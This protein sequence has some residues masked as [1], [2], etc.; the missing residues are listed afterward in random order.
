[1]TVYTLY[2]PKAGQG[3][4]FL[5]A[6]FA[7]S[8][9]KRGDHVILIDA[10][11][12]SPGMEKYFPEAEREILAKPGL[13]DL[14]EDF[15]HHKIEAQQSPET[16][17]TIPQLGNY[18]T[19]VWGADG[20]PD[21]GS[22]S[23]LGAGQRDHKQ[24][25]SYQTTVKET[26]STPKIRMLI[27]HGFFD[28]FRDELQKRSTSIVIDTP[29]G[30]SFISD[31]FLNYM[32]DLVIILS[33]ASFQ[34]R[35]LTV[36]TIDILEDTS[37]LKS[38]VEAPKIPIVVLPVLKNLQHLLP[39]AQRDY[40]YFF[41]DSFKLQMP[42]SWQFKGQ[43]YWDLAI[44]C[45]QSLPASETVL[46]TGTR[47]GISDKGVN[48]MAQLT[49]NILAAEKAFEVEAPEPPEAKTL[50][51]V[52]TAGILIV[53]DETE[54]LS[55]FSRT[56][57]GKF[58]IQNRMVESYD[59]AMEELTQADFQLLIVSINL[60]HSD[61]SG[62]QYGGID[63]L[64]ELEKQRSTVPLVLL[65]SGTLDDAE[66]S[67]L[68]KRFRNIEEV[69]DKRSTPQQLLAQMTSIIQSHVTPPN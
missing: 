50:V 65:N 42:L 35:E 45:L 52:S 55:A 61:S 44:P 69:I 57:L 9:Y 68:C 51:P 43:S 25:R 28:W 67:N 3:Q 40:E 31:T 23:V 6:H 11:L 66:L 30:L 18:V 29:G 39:K 12:P 20:N 56:I 14:F 27:G 37:L 58:D 41:R 49:T 48:Q 19:P 2:S 64:M 15:E 17:G 33:D 36:Q 4:T 60:N 53:D 21:H 59:A 5:A 62:L 24:L 47:Q 7:T 1:M 32:A 8:L 38:Q 10:N 54:W 46:F 13:L 63:I 22:V 26:L 34:S 16:G